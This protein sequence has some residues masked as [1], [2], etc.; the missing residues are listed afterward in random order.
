MAIVS[1]LTTRGRVLVPPEI[2]KKLG[3]TAGSLVAWV[4]RDGEIIVRSRARYASEQLHDAVF[5]GRTARR[6]IRD[7][8]A[9]V[10]AHVRQKHG[11][12]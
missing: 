7:L 6:P 4:E 10:R 3:I 8:D 2:R 11:S 5:E 12:K 9:G 1:K